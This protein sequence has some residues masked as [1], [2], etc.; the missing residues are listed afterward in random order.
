MGVTFSLAA[1]GLL[2]LITSLVTTEKQAGIVNWLVIM[3]MSALGGS[4]FPY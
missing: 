4:M 1:C 2:A 3:G